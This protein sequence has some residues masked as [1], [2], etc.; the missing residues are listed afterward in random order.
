MQNSY[1]EVYSLYLKEKGKAV[2]LELFDFSMN[3]AKEFR[4]KTKKPIDLNMET[5]SFIGFFMGIEASKNE[6]WYRRI[7][8]T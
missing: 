8:E 3:K 6:Y 2:G 4:E 5:A 7:V 1:E